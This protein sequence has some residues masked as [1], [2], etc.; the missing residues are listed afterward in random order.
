MSPPHSPEERATVSNIAKKP[1]SHLRSSAGSSPSSSSVQSLSESSINS[2]ASSK[3]RHREEGKS[4]QSLGRIPKRVKS[5]DSKGYG[6]K[7]TLTL[8][9]LLSRYESWKK[10]L[11][12]KPSKKCV[13]SD[14]FLAVIVT[15]PAESEVMK[16]FESKVPS[17]SDLATYL[18]VT[19][20]FLIPRLQSSGDVMSYCI[21][22]LHKYL[23]G[24]LQKNSEQDNF[25]K[26][27]SA[28]LEV[29]VLEEG[30]QFDDPINGIHV[31]WNDPDFGY[32]GMHPLAEDVA[33]FMDSSCSSSR[34]VPGISIGWSTAN[35]HLYK[36]NRT[37][38][39]G[40]I[41]PF[42][43]K[44]GV[45]G[46]S[47]QR[48]FAIIRIACQAIQYFSPCG[49]NPRPFFHSDPNMRAERAGLAMEFLKSLIVDDSKNVS[50][51]WKDNFHVE[52]ISLIFNNFV[53]FHKDTMNDP[54]S[55]MNDTLSV[56]CT[57]LIITKRLAEIKSVR[58]P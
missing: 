10:F 42:L 37:N 47:A 24:T 52:G 8:E 2:D 45:D 49:R 58:K 31:K 3:R 46:L 28:H 50:D 30:Y 33:P 44:S 4:Y 20:I 16:E 32:R 22:N 25:F 11:S 12:Y 9:L 7:S 41:S 35:A 36:E 27:A 51:H 17:V 55:G 54:T 29:K 14:T 18:S 39:V 56:N 43:I 23:H 40:S 5:H 26:E 6:I 53:S 57:N 38:M 34:K 21:G 15:N 48:R 19:K 1:C 13:P